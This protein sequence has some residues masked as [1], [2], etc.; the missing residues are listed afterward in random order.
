MST[1]GAWAE[2]YRQKWRWDRVGWGSHNVDCYPSGCPLHAYV[3]DGRIVREEAAGSLPQIEAGVPDMNP[4]GCQ[5]GACWAQQHAA[6]D[7]VTHPL[8]RV[9]E[10]GEG[11]FERVSWEEA[12]GD[13]AD[14]MLDAIE[15]QG[16]ESIIVPMTPEMGAAPARLFATLLGP[17]TT[18]GSAEFHDF[19]PGQHI[20]WGVFNPVSSMDDWFHAELTL[21]WHSNPVY[22]YI[23]LY[24]YI[25]ESRYNG[26]EVVTIA[27][28]Y[29]P[30]A[31]HADYHVPVRIG[32]DAALALSMCKVILDAGL[33]QKAFVQEQ[34]DLPLLVRK[35]T[36]RFLRESDLSEG[37][38]DD[39]FFWLDAVT[40]V[41]TP[42]P[43]GTLASAG[44]DPALE[45]SSEVPLAG[46]GSAEV[47]PVFAR[48]RRQLE[49]YSPDRAAEICQIHLDN[50]RKL[51][52][53][54]ATGASGAPG[55]APGP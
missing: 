35:D 3:K 29:S 6:P 22:T 10:R 54:V 13:I 44:A 17:T 42:A 36:G 24:H 52:R 18:D 48:L 40:G 39:Q 20:T 2:A 32:T 16:P 25:A 1:D 26:G 9:G 23:T 31:I 4:M 8:K 34:T 28:D 30:S 33:Y 12:L 43:R 45:G 46:G 49:D 53:K 55:R 38:R 15:E 41:L 50:I 19:H 5:K 37:G 27:P 7:R 21:I 51:A 47:E 11:R 14:R